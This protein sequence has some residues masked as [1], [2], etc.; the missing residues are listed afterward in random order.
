MVLGKGNPLVS[1]GNQAIA[2]LTSAGT[3]D[4]IQAKWLKALSYPTIAQS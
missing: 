3:L 4:A 2:D 1:C